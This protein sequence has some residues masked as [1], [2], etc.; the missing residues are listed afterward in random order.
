MRH[1]VLP[2]ILAFS[3][4]LAAQGQPPTGPGANC[5]PVPG[6]TGVIGEKPPR[7][8]FPANPTR[9]AKPRKKPRRWP[10]RQ[11][12]TNSRKP[13]GVRIVHLPSLV[14][15]LSLDGNKMKSGG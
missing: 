10:P 9:E 5:P 8:D 7:V 14:N 3:T 13:D 1:L 2:L 15:P 6:P 12:Q 11:P 4:P